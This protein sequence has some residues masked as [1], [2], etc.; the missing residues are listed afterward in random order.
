MDWFRYKGGR[1]WRFENSAEGKGTI[2]VEEVES[3]SSFAHVTAPDGGGGYVLRTKGAPSS[4]RNALDDYGAAMRQASRDFGVELPTIFAMMCIEATRVKADRS[5]FNPRSV[6]EEPGYISDEKTPNKVSP[7]LM[8]TLISTAREANAWAGLYRDVSG[9]LEKLS[10]ED[11]FIAERSI[12]LGTAHMKREI[13]NVEPDEARAGFWAHDPIALCAAYNAGSVREGNGAY[14]LRT[15]GGD[16]RVEKF[17]AYHN[18]MVFFQT[19]ST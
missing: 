7:G 11:L 6:R 12:M 5:H 1:G 19:Q 4:A 13:N 3:N 17:V 15:Y 2:I 9:K 16:G 18:D 14:N 10:R 8:Q